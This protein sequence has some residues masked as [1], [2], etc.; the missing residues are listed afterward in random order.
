MSLFYLPLLYFAG[1]AAQSTFFSSLDRK[2]TSRPLKKIKIQWW[3]TFYVPNIHANDSV[4]RNAYIDVSSSATHYYMKLW[5]SQLFTIG[6]S[7]LCRFC[8]LR[9]IGSGQQSFSITLW[10]FCHCTQ[11]I[12]IWNLTKIVQ[13]FRL[14]FLWS[15]L[16]FC[17]CSPLVYFL[18]LPLVSLHLPF[19]LRS[20]ISIPN[21][22]V[23]S[24]TCSTQ[25]ATAHRDMYELA[26]F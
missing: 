21:N 11:I 24:S 19:P 6:N 15:L 8:T 13:L 17:L 16:P 2:E 12:C 18:L 10:L 3:G 22:S 4:A 25:T 26:L 9:A 7:L 14:C 5:Q 23:W 20:S 1:I